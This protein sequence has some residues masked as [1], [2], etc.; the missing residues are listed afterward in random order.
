MREREIF[1]YPQCGPGVGGCRTACR[2]V[3]SVGLTTYVQA[4]FSC[5]TP[6]YSTEY[7]RKALGSKLRRQAKAIMVLNIRRETSLGVSD[8]QSE[9]V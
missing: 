4:E 9:L 7:G 5:G 2:T 6:L 3:Y 1:I 8:I